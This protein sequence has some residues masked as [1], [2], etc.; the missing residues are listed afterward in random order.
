MGQYIISNKVGSLRLFSVTGR[1]PGEPAT[2]FQTLVAVNTEAAAREAAAWAV[3][4]YLGEVARTSSMRVD[5]KLVVRPKT[6]GE[7]AL[8]GDKPWE[9]EEPDGQDKGKE[10]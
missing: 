1:I 7:A 6:F 3:W 9:G 2:V 5:T 10:E 4:E 8:D